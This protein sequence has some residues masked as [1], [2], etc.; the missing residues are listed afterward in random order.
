MTACKTLQRLPQE[1]HVRLADVLADDVESVHG[2][3]GHGDSSFVRT[4]ILFHTRMM[5]W[6]TAIQLTGYLHHVLGLY[7][8]HFEGDE[9]A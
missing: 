3:R 6:P 9:V 8:S 1:V 2:G 5:P 4:L 7:S